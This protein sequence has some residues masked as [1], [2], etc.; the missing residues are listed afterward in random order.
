MM[1]NACH[2]QEHVMT[3]WT[4]LKNH[5]SELL[6]VVLIEPLLQLRMQ[7]GLQE[8]IF[9]KLILIRENWEKPTLI[10]SISFSTSVPSKWAL[11]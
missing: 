8:D 3:K 9:P 11:Y 2:A 5:T 1:R 6:I 4:K 7:S 10:L